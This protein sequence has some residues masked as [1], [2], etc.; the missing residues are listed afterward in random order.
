MKYRE[1]ARKLAALG[2]SETPRKGGGSHRKEHNPAT[3]R[4]TVVPDGGGRDLKLGTVRSAV[5]QLG[6]DWSA[7][8]N[9]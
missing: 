6:I 3:G 7:F 9:A 4:S 8:E 1:V 5:R 2:C